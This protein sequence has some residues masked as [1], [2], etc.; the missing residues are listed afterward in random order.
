[1]GQLIRY[2]GTPLAA[3]GVGQGLGVSMGQRE[4][5]SKDSF[6]GREAEVGT[7]IIDYGAD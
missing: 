4:H 7:A 6:S 5:K 2:V 3:S 1:M